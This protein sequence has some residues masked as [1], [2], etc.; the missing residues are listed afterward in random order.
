MGRHRQQQIVEI[1][2]SRKGMKFPPEHGCGHQRL[3]PVSNQ[4]VGSIGAIPIAAAAKLSKISG[5]APAQRCSRVAGMLPRRRIRRDEQP[6]LA[7]QSHSTT[8]AQDDK[9][10][11]HQSLAEET[12]PKQA[13]L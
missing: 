8:V 9:N 5:V 3:L 7:V 10:E 6:F 1:V 12:A 4:L 2:T 13:E 11:Q